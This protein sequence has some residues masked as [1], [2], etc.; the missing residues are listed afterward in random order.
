MSELQSLQVLEPDGTLLREIPTVGTK[1]SNLTFA[2]RDGVTVFVTQV[3]GRLIES[4]RV[5]R[6]GR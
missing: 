6:P 2:G 5:D 1:P 3:D 4:F